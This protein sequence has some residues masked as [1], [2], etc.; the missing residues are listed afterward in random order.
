MSDSHLYLFGISP[1]WNT[2]IFV[3]Q[4]IVALIIWQSS[5]ATLPNELAHPLLRMLGGIS[6]RLLMA[7]PSWR[8]AITLSTTPAS[9]HTT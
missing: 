5:T 7:E 9:Q 8:H 2:A 1:F 3:L 6:L 4:A